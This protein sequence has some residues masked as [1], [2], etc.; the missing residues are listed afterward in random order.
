[1]GASVTKFGLNPAVGGSYRIRYEHRY[2]QLTQGKT[3]P[4]STGNAVNQGASAE[5][6]LVYQ[7][8]TSLVGAYAA[9]RM[10]R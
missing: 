6:A 9:F 1:M 5:M 3:H 10:G 4:G 2:S 7:C 8:W